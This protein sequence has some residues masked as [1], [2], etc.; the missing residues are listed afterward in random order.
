MSGVLKRGLINTLTYM[1]NSINT[2]YQS[3]HFNNRTTYVKLELEGATL[4]SDVI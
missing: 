2:E 4:A 3:T 1:I